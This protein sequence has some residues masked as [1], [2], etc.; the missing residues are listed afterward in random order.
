MLWWR[1]CLLITDFDGVA[2]HVPPLG[3]NPSCPDGR[4]LLPGCPEVTDY[5][6]NSTRE[7][8]KRPLNVYLV[9]GLNG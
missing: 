7:Y 8:L 2:V 9:K 4:R 6:A 1:L 3:D 5:K